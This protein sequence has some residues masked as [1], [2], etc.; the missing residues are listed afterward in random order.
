[1]CVC[2]CVCVFFNY[3]LCGSLSPNENIVQVQG[4]N[5]DYFCHP[6]CTALDTRKLSISYLLIQVRIEKEIILRG[7]DIS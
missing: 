7:E 2:V 5:F 3:F 4:H 6:Y 1:M